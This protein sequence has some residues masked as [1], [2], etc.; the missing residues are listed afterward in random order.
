MRA[1]PQFK[2][3]IEKSGQHTVPLLGQL[4]RK[5]SN[6]KMPFLYQETLYPTVLSKVAAFIVVPIGASPGHRHYSFTGEL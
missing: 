2:R 4:K 5:N 1:G 3:L 6:S